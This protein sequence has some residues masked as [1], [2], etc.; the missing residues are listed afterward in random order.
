MQIHEF[1]AALQRFKATK[2]FSISPPELSSSIEEIERFEK[3]SGIRLPQQYRHVA[4]NVGTGSIGFAT[5]FSATSAPEGIAAQRAS[6]PSL[7][8]N[9]VPISDNGC[10]DF[11]GFIV[12]AGQCGEEIYFADHECGYQIARTEFSNLFEYLVRYAFNAA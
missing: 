9:F 12:N 11:Y 4:V 6:V 3:T 10:G 8:K 1:D 2:A 5:L 7:P